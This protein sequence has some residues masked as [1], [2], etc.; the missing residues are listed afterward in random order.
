MFFALLSGSVNAEPERKNAFKQ[1]QEFLEKKVYGEIE[2]Y[3]DIDG[4]ADLKLYL[5]RDNFEHSKSFQSKPADMV[6]AFFGGYA[7][8]RPGP[9]GQRSYL[10]LANLRRRLASERGVVT[11]IFLACY[12]RID[13]GHAF[14]FS[15]SNL[16]NVGRATTKELIAKL[17]HEISL[18]KNKSVLLLGHSYGGWLAMKS[19]LSLATPIKIAG[20]ITLDP[21]S[22]VDCKPHQFGTRLALQVLGEPSLPGCQRAPSDISAEDRGKI[23]ARSPYWWNLF[24]TATPELHSGPI[25][26]AVH[27]EFVSYDNITYKGTAHGHM[28]E[29]PRV[30]NI[31][32]PQ[33]LRGATNQDGRKFIG[34]SEGEA[35]NMVAEKNGPLALVSELSLR[36]FNTYRKA[37]LSIYPSKKAVQ[38]AKEAGYDEPKVSAY[39]PT[40]NLHSA[41]LVASDIILRP[42]TPTR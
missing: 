34:I 13:R 35:K 7:S 9:L 18:T 17:E 26:E 12:G 33:I 21:I 6:L 14:Y 15:S 2:G 38:A 5:D 3:E 31:I 20:F 39:Q 1:G 42:A 41:L 4:A 10:Q 32:A 24:Q 11:R 22:Q 28:Q 25:L 27:N 23:A 37:T 40:S 29:D 30:W 8:C 36:M 19:V 16:N